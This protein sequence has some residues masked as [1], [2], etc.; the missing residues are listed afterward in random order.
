M[1][2]R[3]RNCCGIVIIIIIIKTVVLTQ[4]TEVSA[5]LFKARPRHPRLEVS[6]R[7]RCFSHQLKV[8]ALR[9]TIPLLSQIEAYVIVKSTISNSL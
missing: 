3:I 2:R 5:S 6:P 9:K 8:A 1:L 7:L 4:K